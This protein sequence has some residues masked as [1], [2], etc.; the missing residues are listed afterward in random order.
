MADPAAACAWFA[1]WTG[2]RSSGP[3][4]L[5]SGTTEFTFHA[6]DAENGTG[7]AGQVAYLGVRNFDETRAGLKRAGATLYRGPLDR[8]DGKRMAQFLDPFGNVVGIIGA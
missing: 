3:N 8:E 4:R 2:A 1:T 7:T 6:A 5:R